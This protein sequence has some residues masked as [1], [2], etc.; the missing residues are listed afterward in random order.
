MTPFAVV[1]SAHTLTLGIFAAVIAVTLAVT[2]SR[3][4]GLGA[5]SAIVLIVLGPLVWPGGASSTPFPLESPVLISVPLG[6]AGCVLGTLLASDRRRSD[7][8][9]SCTYVPRSAS[10][11]NPARPSALEQLGLPLGAVL[12]TYGAQRHKIHFTGES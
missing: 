10:A 12:G 11:P 1:S 7:A 2:R 8:F 6:F 5:V 4:S 9:R 3:A